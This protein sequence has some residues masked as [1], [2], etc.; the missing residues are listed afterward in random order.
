MKK[1]P[2]A[3]LLATMAYAPYVH[4]DNI[5]ERGLKEIG[6]IARCIVGCPDPT[7]PTSPPQPRRQRTQQRP[8]SQQRHYVFDN[9]LATVDSAKGVP[10]DVWCGPEDYKII[11]VPTA[12]KI[13]RDRNQRLEIIV[14]ETGMNAAQREIVRKEFSYDSKGITITGEDAEKAN[15]AGINR[16]RTYI[17]LKDAQGRQLASQKNETLDITYKADCGTTGSLVTQI[18]NVYPAPKTIEP[19][20]KPVELPKPVET[21]APTSVVP[22]PM[23]KEDPNPL[24]NV[25]KKTGDVSIGIGP[26][27]QAI[28]YVNPGATRPSDRRVEEVFQ[29]Y[30]VRFKARRDSEK[31]SIGL[32]GAGSFLTPQ[33]NTTTYTP[34]FGFSEGKQTAFALAPDVHVAVGNKLKL[35]LDAEAEYKTVAITDPEV[36]DADNTNLSGG[37]GLS[38]MGGGYNR[39]RLIVGVMARQQNIGLHRADMNAGNP[40]RTDNMQE[41]WGE[42]K[43]SGQKSFGNLSVYGSYAVG[44]PMTAWT[45]TFKPADDQTVKDPQKIDDSQYS[46][47]RLGAKYWTHT[48]TERPRYWQLEFGQ[49]HEHTTFQNDSVLDVNGRKVTLDYGW[50]F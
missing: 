44:K 1:L 10:K 46:N 50:R 47:L 25:F 15:K 43:V 45:S 37:L 32:Q 5:V 18:V 20:P 3:V 22:K 19:A 49:A 31:R 4:A 6:R 21:P 42:F 38:V 8:V 29:G 7:K 23:P 35:A 30:Q 34:G 41:V 11:Q 48:Q 39:D 26:V 27:E 33:G 36:V 14:D 24:E 9:E 13:H 40:R 28:E 17:A 2:T 16:L 12:A